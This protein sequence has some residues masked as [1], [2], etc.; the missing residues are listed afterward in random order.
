MV[1]VVRGFDLQVGE[2]VARLCPGVETYKDWGQFQALGV[3][4]AGT[5]LAGVVY[6]RYSGADVYMAIASASPKWA[7]K[8]VIRELLDHAF[9]TL[10]C[11]RVTAVTGIKNKR[12]RR[13]LTLLGFVEEGKKRLGL[14]GKEDLMI[15]GLLK[16][17]SRHVRYKRNA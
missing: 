5:L 10:G 6:Y 16:E 13:L 8:R 1:E 7:S 12:A 4:E 11:V 3:A 14:Y 2:F 17:E 9:V 15:Y